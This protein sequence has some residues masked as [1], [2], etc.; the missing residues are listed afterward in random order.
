[1]KDKKG[2]LIGFSGASGSGKT[3]LVNLISEEL[4]KEGH[5]V[6]VVDE[7]VRKVFTDYSKTYGFKSLNEIRKSDRFVEF[8]FQIFGSQYFTEE[9]LR[10]E[11]EVVITDRTIFDSIMYT[12]F[13]LDPFKLTDEDKSKL[14]AMLRLVE[15]TNKWGR[16]DA[17]FHCYPLSGDV[18]DGFRTPDLGY[19]KIQDALISLLLPCNAK[20]FVVPEMPLEDRVLFVKKCLERVFGG[21]KND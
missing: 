18:D 15:Y 9:I 16:Y 13:W 12:V 14:Q 2:L 19:R 3:T 5:D 11:Y 1:M 8:Q 21:E 6:V 20:V 7:I 17:I 10:K 4:K